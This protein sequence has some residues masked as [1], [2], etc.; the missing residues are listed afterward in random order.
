[1]AGGLDKV[2]ASVNTVINQLEPVDPI[3]LFEVGVESSIDIFHNWFPAACQLR[4]VR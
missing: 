2:D 4:I 3:F 1:M